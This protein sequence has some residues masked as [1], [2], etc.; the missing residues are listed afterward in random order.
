MGFFCIQGRSV[1]RG[2]FFI[3]VAS[4]ALTPLFAGDWPTYRGPKADG[5]ADG[6]GVFNGA[7]PGIETI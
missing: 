7:S 2:V 6:E 5:S 1:V 3:L 4:L